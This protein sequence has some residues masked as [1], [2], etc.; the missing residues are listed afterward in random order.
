MSIDNLW[1][2]DEPASNWVE[3]PEWIEQDITAA[4]VEAINQ[5][6]CASGAYMPAVINYKAARTMAEH[7]D[8]VLDYIESHLGELPQPPSGE[9]WSGMACF[10][11]SYAVEVWAIDAYDGIR[12]AIEEGEAA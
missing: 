11:L 5:G 8:A 10:F 7:G 9:S 6:G 2:I 4:D 3:V 1:D 12:E